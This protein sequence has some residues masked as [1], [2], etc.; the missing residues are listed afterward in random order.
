MSRA[1]ATVSVL[2]LVV[3]ACSGTGSYK[4]RTEDFI[5]DDSTVVALA[6]ADVSS[7]ECEEPPSAEVDTVYACTAEVAGIGPGTFEVEIVADDSFL[8]IEFDPN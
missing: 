1:V 6:G 2:I 4:S 8:V 3:T 5:N 7:A